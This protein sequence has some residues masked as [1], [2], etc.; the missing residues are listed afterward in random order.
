MASSILASA[1]P[2]PSRPLPQPLRRLS[3]VLAALFLAGVVFVALFAPW[4]TPYH[5]SRDRGAP[6]QPSS[7]SHPLGTDEQG[8]D[9]LSRLF[10][11]ARVSL[12]VAVSVE[13][14][15]LA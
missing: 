11:G 1:P 8:R 5:Y 10:Y 6:H 7:P 2:S 14:V 3:T 12:I 15:E 9:M 4:L 13:A